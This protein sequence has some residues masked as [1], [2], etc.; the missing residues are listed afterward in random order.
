MEN[1]HKVSTNASVHAVS[2]TSLGQRQMG[3]VTQ[4]TL[5]SN[6]LTTA[7]SSLLRGTTHS[8]ARRNSRV[9][10]PANHSSERNMY[11]MGT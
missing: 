1:E 5:P 10:Q 8:T 9:V 4:I 2:Y 6:Q 3:K 7:I 11:I